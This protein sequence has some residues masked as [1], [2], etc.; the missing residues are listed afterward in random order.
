MQ[1]TMPGELAEGYKSASQ[2][3][4]VVSE[5]WAEENL[6]C[7]NCTSRELAACPTN[8]EAVDFLCPECE[9]PFQL[10]SQSRP[11]TSR[12]TDAA[13]AAMVRAIRAG[14]NPNLFVLHYDMVRWHVLNLLLVPRFS[15]SISALEKRKPLSP[16]ARRSGWIGC[17]IVLR[18]FPTDAKISVVSDGVIADPIIVRRQFERL[19]PL[20]KLKIDARGWTLDVLNIVRGLGR[21]EFTL[22]EVYAEEAALGR[23]HPQNRFVRPKIRQ[24]LQILR[25]LGFVEF[26]GDGSYRLM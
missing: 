9:A 10:K 11:F 18:N 21:R 2:R 15:F 7:A 5:A 22:A 24:Q 3:A 23:L 4:R 14:R 8:T 17:N 1:L 26:L 19:R 6:Y 13:F 12:V 20:E 16:S 25:D